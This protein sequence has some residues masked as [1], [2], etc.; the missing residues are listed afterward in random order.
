VNSSN[1]VVVIG[2]GE[3]GA[4]LM[5]LISERFEVTGVDVTPVEPPPYVEVMHICYPFQI[6]DFVG[7][8]ARYIDLFKPRLTVINSTVAVGTTRAIAD[9]TGTEVVNSPIRGKHAQMI[10]DLRSYTKFVGALNSESAESAVRHF[11]SI[12]L[13]VQVV[14]SPETTELAKLSETTYF[15]L[16]I[17]WAQE[18]ERYCARAGVDYDEVTSFYGEIKYFPPVNYFAGIIGGHCVMPNIEILRKFDDSEMLSAIVN[19]N[20]MKIHREYDKGRDSAVIRAATL[21]LDPLTQG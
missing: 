16:L 10:K 3:I 5:Q 1:C 14:G 12:G 20:M 4:P 8:T 21:A 11:E 13:N 2:L 15:G 9:R 19:S 6:S 17:G 18:V 7:E